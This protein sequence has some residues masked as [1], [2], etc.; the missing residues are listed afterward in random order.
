MSTKRYA[1][2]PGGPERLEISMDLLYNLKIRL[3]GKEAGQIPD[4]ESRTGGE[5]RLPDGSFL[6][7]RVVTGLGTKLVVQRNGTPLPGSDVG[8]IGATKASLIQRLEKQG[9]AEGLL[10]ILTDRT[11]TL[12]E[13]KLAVR[14]LGSMGKP[15]GIDSLDTIIH[16]DREETDFRVETALALRK[17][18]YPQAVQPFI[19]ALK[20]A[21]D[22][23]RNSAAKI[24]MDVGGPQAKEALE[25]YYYPHLSKSQRILSDP[26]ARHIFWGILLVSPLLL[27]GSQPFLNDLVKSTNNILSGIVVLGSIGGFY[28]GLNML[29]SVFFGDSISFLTPLFVLFKA[30]KCK[31][32]GHTM[33]GSEYRHDLRHGYAICPNCKSEVIIE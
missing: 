31:N 5:V 22:Q 6:K 11:N 25:T 27:L 13:R 26:V 33:G 20:V 24:L 10:L 29:W 17:L 21:D 23:N 28:L 18:G 9:D 15:I 30:S 16:D 14:A 2:E 4:P 8:Q 7:V 32:C 3:D 1:L 12:P 19:D